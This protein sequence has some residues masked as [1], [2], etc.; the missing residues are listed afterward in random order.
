MPVINS[1]GILQT[2]DMQYK[3][4]KSM[5]LVSSFYK[6]IIALVSGKVNYRWIKGLKLFLL[7]KSPKGD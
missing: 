6:M 7:G 2:V 4:I 1:Q 5:S 3:L